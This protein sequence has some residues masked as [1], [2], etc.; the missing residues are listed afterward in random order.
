MIISLWEDIVSEA[1][2]RDKEYW[3]VDLAQVY[4]Q[5]MFEKLKLFILPACYLYHS[6]ASPDSAEEVIDYFKHDEIEAV[7]ISFADPRF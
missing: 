4:N 6:Y 7:T 5:D 1:K 3:D 2:K